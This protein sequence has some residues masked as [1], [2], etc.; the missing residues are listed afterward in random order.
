MW[1]SPNICK[2][3]DWFLACAFELTSSHQIQFRKFQKCIIHKTTPSNILFHPFM[4]NLL[5]AYPIYLINTNLCSNYPPILYEIICIFVTSV[6]NTLVGFT[7]EVFL[8]VTTAYKYSLLRGW[9]NI[10]INPWKLF[11]QA[12]EFSLARWQV[13]PSTINFLGWNRCCIAD[14]VSLYA[15]GKSSPVLGSSNDMIYPAR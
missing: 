14:S 10:C 15:L 11:E 9:C 1:I 3:I 6:R 13:A 4:L 8:V 7:T 2:T 12:R 5:F